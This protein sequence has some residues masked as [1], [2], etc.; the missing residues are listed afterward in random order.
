MV[1]LPTKQNCCGDGK[2]GVIFP[3]PEKGG[4][5]KAGDACCLSPDEA[6]LGVYMKRWEARFMS[7]GDCLD[8]YNKMQGLNENDVPAGDPRNHALRTLGGHFIGKKFCKE[9]VCGK[10]KQ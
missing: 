10:K 6:E 8:W 7:L 2:K 9:L 5:K 3:K 4:E 1:Y